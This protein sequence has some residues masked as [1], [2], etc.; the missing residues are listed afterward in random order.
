MSA[1][2][3]I[4]VVAAASGPVLGSVRGTIRSEGTGEAIAGVQVSVES[5]SA[6]TLSD[7]TGSYALGAL[8]PGRHLLRFS[9]FGYH[10]L[11][12]EVTVPD[13]GNLELDVRLRPRP[14]AVPAISLFA[15]PDADL[16]EGRR[17]LGPLPPGS[18]ALTVGAG[19]LTSEPDVLLALEAVP[20]VDLPEESPT[21]FHIHGGSADQNQL[22]VDGIPVY[23]AYH[24]SGVFAGVN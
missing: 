7:T 21:G 15:G 8:P 14:I 23:N 1:L 11:I 9:Q 22:L 16:G 10:D 17:S 19:P 5:T 24:T 18:R 3:W 2:A 6:V 12:V 20:G 4:A 13:G